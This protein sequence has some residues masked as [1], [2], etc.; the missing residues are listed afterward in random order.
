MGGRCLWA[1]E[2]ELG[3]H[4]SSPQGTMVPLLPI[5]FAVFLPLRALQEFWLCPGALP[6][7]WH[8]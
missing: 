2:A 6:L 1:H 5:P 4:D 7:L 8:Q 3:R